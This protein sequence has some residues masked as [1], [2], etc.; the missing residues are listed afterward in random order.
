MS[1][2][3]PRR[4]RRFAC[5]TSQALRDVCLDAFVLRRE[6]SLE[7]RAHQHD[8][9]A[10]TVVLVLERE[11]RRT[12]LESE[13][14]MDAS[15]DAGFFARQRTIRQRTLGRHND[16]CAHAGSPRIPI[17]NKCFGSNVR[18]IPADSRSAVGDGA[19]AAHSSA[20]SR[21]PIRL[22]SVESTNCRRRALTDASL[23]GTMQRTTPRA[24]V[25]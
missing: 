13:S 10:R 24:A 12:A 11:I 18:L 21:S 1:I 5:A 20:G 22:T 19:H 3:N 15:V 25:A 23:R 2:G 17:F 16:G 8:S 7:Q 9:A 14:A 6:R 4:T